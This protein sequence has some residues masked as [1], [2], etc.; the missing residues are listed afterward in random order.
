M[1]VASVNHSQTNLSSN[2]HAPDLASS[3]SVASS[4]AKPKAGV[5]A[6]VVF[7]LNFSHDS[8]LEV[9]LK[10][11]M[12]F[13]TWVVQQNVCDI[14]GKKCKLS[15]RA[16]LVANSTRNFTFKNTLLTVDNCN[17]LSFI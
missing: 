11:S 14:E 12:L 4:G 15:Q 7:F 2:I 16:I 9:K 5:S 3:S 6:K 10:N 8:R 17:K 1:D 13:I